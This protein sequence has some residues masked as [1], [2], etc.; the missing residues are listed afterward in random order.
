M[1]PIYFVLPA[2]HRLRWPKMLKEAACGRCSVNDAAPYFRDGKDVFLLQAWMLLREEETPFSFH[3]V[4]KAVPNQI[5]VFHYDTARAKH[6]LFDCFSIVIHVD[7]P[8]VPYADIIVEQRP[9]ADASAYYLPHWVQ[10]GIT[11]RDADRG[12]RL[13]RVALIGNRQ[14]HPAFMSD[15]DFLAQL[16]RLGITLV[17]LGPEAWTNFQDIDAVVALRPWIAP[18]VLRTKP[19]T[20]L[21]NAWAADTPALLGPEPAYRSL[22]LNPLDYLEVTGSESVL[23]ALRRLKEA[24]ELYAAMRERCQARADE[25]AW[26]NIK[27]KWLDLFAHAVARKDDGAPGLVGKYVRYHAVRA[28]NSLLRHTGLWND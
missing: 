1:T 17:A 22:R 2:S 6:G 12:N 10:P 28:Y 9:V 20:K 21:I 5:C 18:R 16:A 11:R 3:L 8:I 7:R 14:Y 27:G 4:E 23:Y 26:E 25:Y 19:P 15:P 24:P 13:E